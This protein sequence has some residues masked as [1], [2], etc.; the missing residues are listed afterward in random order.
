MSIVINRSSLVL[1]LDWISFSSEKEG[2]GGGGGRGG[3]VD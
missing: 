1:G 3:V 2:G